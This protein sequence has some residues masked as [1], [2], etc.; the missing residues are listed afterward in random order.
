MK[1]KELVAILK[2]LDQ[3]AI[4][5]IASD[6]EGN[7]FGDMSKEFSEGTLAKTKQKVYSFYPENNELPE[8]RYS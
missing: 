7:S 1:V 4:I 2:N 8:E 5:D 6:E 3:E